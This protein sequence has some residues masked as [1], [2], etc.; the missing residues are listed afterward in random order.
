MLPATHGTL[1]HRAIWSSEESVSF[2]QRLPVIHEWAEE[3]LKK[4]PSCQHQG[5]NFLP[6]RL[7]D[8]GE[9]PGSRVRLVNSKNIVILP[10][11]YPEFLAL[12]HCWGKSKPSMILC[13]S[14]MD[15]LS[16]GVELA[17]LPRTFKDAAR[18]TQM[19]GKR[20]LWI[21]SLCIIQGSS[22]DWQR[23]AAQMDSVY[24]NAYL[25]IAAASST[26]SEGG[27]YIDDK[28]ATMVQTVE[29]PFPDSF[30]MIAKCRWRPQDRP[31]LFDSSLLHSRGWI[32][33]EAVLS[34]RT[35]YF[36]KDQLIWERRKKHKREDGS[37]SLSYRKHPAHRRN[38]YGAESDSSSDRRDQWWSWI[39][40]YTQ[41]QLSNPVI[42]HQLSPGSPSSSQKRAG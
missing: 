10:D 36:T 25:T 3:C 42:G 41:P 35:V 39:W 15:I 26:D 6:T 18:V 29:I 19:L 21:D 27:L 7:L 32:L 8:V 31:E 40:D 37:P 22:A 23:E 12:S 2:P 24:R 9:K 28:L 14:S 38:I 1:A 5:T 16:S 30:E 20:Y 4:H 17:D 13:S 34:R 11:N 33:Q